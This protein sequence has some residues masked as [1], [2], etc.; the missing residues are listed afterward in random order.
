M[1]QDLQQ[2]IRF[3]VSKVGTSG[4]YIA[5]VGGSSRVAEIAIE[6]DHWLSSRQKLMIQKLWKP[7]LQLRH[8]R[9]SYTPTRHSQLQ[10]RS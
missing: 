6:S 2:R 9:E 8:Q 4:A 10:N 7:C 5:I 1:P 3:C